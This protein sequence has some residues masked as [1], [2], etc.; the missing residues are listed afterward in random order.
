MKYLTQI[1]AQRI[2]DRIME[3]VPY[4]INI[5]DSNGLIIASGD[6]NRIGT[7][8]QGAQKAIAM[9]KIYQVDHDT[10]TERKGINLPI[11]FGGQLLGVIGISGD[12]DQVMQLGMLVVTTA[13]LMIENDANN[14]KIAAEETRMNNF[15]FE[16]THRSAKEYSKEFITQ[17][18]YYHVNLKKPRV[19]AFF[20]LDP[21]DYNPSHAIRALLGPEDYLVS[22]AMNSVTVI[23]DD[24]D[25]YLRKTQKI[26]AL[27]THFR[28]A[29]VG[30]TAPTAMEAIH[31]T[32]RLVS[33]AQRLQVPWAIVY[34]RQLLLESKFAS[35]PSDAVTC[36]VMEQLRKCET[37]D[38]LRLTILNYVEHSDDLK[39]V[40]DKLFIHRNTLNY[41]IEKI[42]EATGLNLKNGKDMMLLYISALQLS[43]HAQEEK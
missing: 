42:R 43:M 13:Q 11:F 40:C 19:A 32:H 34:Y 4:N 38:T 1:N 22:Q 26:M 21:G 20:T 17:A 29:Y 3:I 28:N 24:N 30:D 12:P 10:S 2:A 36:N 15:F 16:W 31:S 14:E 39:L 27:S 7:L 6:K 25:S 41:R 33:V 37:G 23:F 35:L 9:R 8:H 5:M 18:D